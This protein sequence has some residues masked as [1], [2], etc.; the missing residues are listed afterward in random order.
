[1]L[2]HFIFLSLCD[3]YFIDTHFEECQHYLRMATESEKYS[4]VFI[5]KNI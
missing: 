1:M 4:I 3:V 5:C 2:T